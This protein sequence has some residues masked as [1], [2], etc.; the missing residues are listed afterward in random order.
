MEP[1]KK[2][3][4]SQELSIV[5]EEV[6]FSEQSI[7]SYHTA[8]GTTELKSVIQDEYSRGKPLE[9]M[10][11]LLNTNGHEL[12]K[13]EPSRAHIVLFKIQEKV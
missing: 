13:I 8:F 12:V 7:K 5:S 1:E 9:E 11:S 4:F 3:E 2:L 6:V 10:A